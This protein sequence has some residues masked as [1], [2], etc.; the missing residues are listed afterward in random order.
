MMRK[1]IGSHGFTRDAMRTHPRNGFMPM[2]GGIR[3]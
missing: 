1:K 2:R 3:F